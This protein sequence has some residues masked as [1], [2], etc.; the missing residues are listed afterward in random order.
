FIRRNRG[1]CDD[2]GAMVRSLE[3][4]LR[5]KHGLVAPLVTSGADLAG[6]QEALLATL[7][8][9]ST[10]LEDEG[11][12]RKERLREI[13]YLDGLDEAFGPTGRFGRVALPGVLPE[14]LPD[15]I[16]VVLT[17]RPG[18]HLP[19]LADPALCDTVGADP[20]SGDY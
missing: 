1:R 9:V 19:W 12:R 6:L 7:R 13:V 10:K 5:R 3:A 18:E 11:K 16:F 2:P 15:G 20:S 8:R 14:E 4:Q 17:S